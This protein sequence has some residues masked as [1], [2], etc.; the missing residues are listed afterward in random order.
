MTP[1]RTAAP[2]TLAIVADSTCDLTAEEARDL[3]VDIMPLHVEFQGKTYLDGVDITTADILAGSPPAPT[4]PA[5]AR[6]RRTLSWAPSRRRPTRE[7]SRCS[8]SP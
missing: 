8:A 5:P 6:S 7:P 4:C 1:Q 2:R 3:G